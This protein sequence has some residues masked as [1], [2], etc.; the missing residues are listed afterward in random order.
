MKLFF[1]NFFKRKQRL[2]QRL[3]LISL[4]VNKVVIIHY[5]VFYRKISYTLSYFIAIFVGISI[6]KGKIIS[7]KNQKRNYF[8]WLLGLLLKHVAGFFYCRS[9]VV[10]RSL[11][12]TQVHHF[13]SFC[14]Q[15]LERGYRLVLCWS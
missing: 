2:P 3:R 10:R 8:L 5:N 1:K 11:M 12:F 14:K 7:L 13:V 6:F 4:F 9:C 15:T